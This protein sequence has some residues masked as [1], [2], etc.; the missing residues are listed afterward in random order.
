[1]AELVSKTKTV[2][3]TCFA[4]LLSYAMTFTNSFVAFL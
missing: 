2:N 3:A 1:M 4:I